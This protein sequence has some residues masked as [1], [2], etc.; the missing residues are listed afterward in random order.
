MGRKG[1]AQRYAA[2]MR[3]LLVTTAVL[4]AIVASAAGASAKTGFEFGRVGGNIRPFT[5]V[6]AN[7]GAVTATGAAPAHTPAVTKQ[8]LAELNRIA[9]EIAFDRLPLVTSCPATL[10]D[11]AAQVIRVGGRTV[12][13]H[14]GCLH[15]FNRLWTALNR[16]T[17]R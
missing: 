12:R 11:V 4:L 13:V 14:G 1:N 7:T 6:I 3:R 15:R 17:V 9:F 10:P 2:A 5:I 16:T 8:Q